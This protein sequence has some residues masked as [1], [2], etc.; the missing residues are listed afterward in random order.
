[1]TALSVVIPALDAEPWLGEQLDAL[2][3]QVTDFAWEVILADNG[4]R[5]QTK[6]AFERSSSRLPASTWVD[7]SDRAG[8]A[9][10]RNVGAKLAR[11]GFLVFVDADDVVAPG[12]LAAMH[13]ALCSHALVAARLDDGTSSASDPEEELQPYLGFL[14]AAAGGSLGVRRELFEELGGFD[15]DLPPAEDVDLCWRALLGGHELVRVSEAVMWYRQR[16]TLRAVFRRAFRYAAIRPLL[17]RR[18]RQAGMPR[19]HGVV[20]L[21]F[22]LGVVPVALKIRSRADLSDWVALVAVR[23]GHLRGSLRYRVWYP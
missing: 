10:A 23:V 18:Y 8:Q 13:A 16:S 9:H 4:S 6:A 20:A 12:Y 19:R 22:Q 11:G 3:S 21:R 17:Y 5:D 15:C 14:P 7:A 2:A 1:M